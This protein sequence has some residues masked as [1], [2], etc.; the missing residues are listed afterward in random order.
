MQGSAVAGCRP[1][2]GCWRWAVGPTWAYSTADIVG[3]TAAKA[4]RSLGCQKTG[5]RRKQGSSK[6]PR[7]TDC[8]PG[9]RE[10]R[11]SGRRRRERKA[12]KTAERRTE[13]GN[14]KVTPEKIA[15]IAKSSRQSQAG[16]DRLV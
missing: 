4:R 13:V 7:K 6:E 15:D 10:S 14:G 9:G 1:N 12:R 3:D 16:I 2:P 11:R 5:C 8:P